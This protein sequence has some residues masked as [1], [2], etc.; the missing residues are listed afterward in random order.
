MYENVCSSALPLTATSGENKTK[1]KVFTETFKNQNPQDVLYMTSFFHYHREVSWMCHKTGWKVIFLIVL[2][3]MR[4]IW[5]FVQ[6][7]CRQ[8]DSYLSKTSIPVT[9]EIG[10]FLCPDSHNKRHRE[11][12]K[13]LP[14]LN[15]T[16]KQLFKTKLSVCGLRVITPHWQLVNQATSGGLRKWAVSHAPHTAT[17]SGCLCWEMFGWVNKAA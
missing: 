13:L 1:S 4:A 8:G 6:S 7:I 5:S 12:A 14:D 16:E 2:I 9:Y 17:Q 15:F 11:Q 3:L 10:T